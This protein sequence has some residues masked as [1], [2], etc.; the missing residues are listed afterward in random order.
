MGVGG[1]RHAPAA[2]PPGKTRYPLYRRLGRPQSLS[3]ELRKI[4]PP[5][6][7]DPRSVRPVAS[8]YTDYAIPAPFR[9]PYIWKVF[10]IQIWR[11]RVTCIVTCPVSR[12]GISGGVIPNVR[13]CQ[14]SSRW[15]PV[16]LWIIH[17]FVIAPTIACLR[18]DMAE[19]FIQECTIE[20]YP[21][22]I[23][24]AAVMTPHEYAV[25]LRQICTDVP[26]ELVP[27]F[28]CWEGWNYFQVNVPKRAK[29]DDL[30]CKATRLPVRSAPYFLFV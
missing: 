8:R 23:L 10:E 3:G 11:K 17:C 2:L 29:R 18:M 25:S 22:N 27:P 20:L 14:C 6:W 28:S 1:E 19:R 24:V 26:S 13:V 4:S 30:G 12:V 9:T 15:R 16:N 5:P 21:I 7:F